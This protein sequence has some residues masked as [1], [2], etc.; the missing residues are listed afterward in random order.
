MA[1][2]KP[3]QKFSE[4]NKLGGRPELPSVVRTSRRL[5]KLEFIEETT[6]LLDVPI[7]R[8]KEIVSDPKTPSG[9]AAVASIILHSIQKG[10]ANKFLAL[11][12]H[13]IGKPKET[14]EVINP[15]ADPVAQ[16]TGGLEEQELDN[17]I[18]ALRARLVNPTVDPNE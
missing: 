15:T 16:I 13:V 1:N 4:G 11:M 9:R 2:P 17:E 6:Y 14:V 12:S 10:D 7:D 5:T 8:L 18:R 3:S